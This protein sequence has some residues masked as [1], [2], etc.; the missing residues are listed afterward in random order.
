MA[1]DE[2]RLAQFDPAPPAPVKKGSKRGDKTVTPDADIEVEQRVWIAAATAWVPEG[3]CLAYPLVQQ[4]AGEDLA[5]RFALADWK[6]RR[7]SVWS[8]SARS[9]WRREGAVL[10]DKQRRLAA[11][12]KELRIRPVPGLGKRRQS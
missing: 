3:W 11:C 5:W 1:S 8:F 2:R 10:A 12:A 9:A 4:L 6:A 7:P